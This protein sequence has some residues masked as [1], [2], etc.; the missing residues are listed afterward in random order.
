MII[1]QQAAQS[2]RLGDLAGIV[3]S[4]VGEG[5]GVFDS[6]MIAFGVVVRDIFPDAMPEG[7]LTVKDHLVEAFGLDGFNEMLRK[8]IE[9]GGACLAFKMVH[10]PATWQGLG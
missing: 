1:L 8:G 2:F 10:L 5:D 3:Q 6:L 7:F 4:F 9:I